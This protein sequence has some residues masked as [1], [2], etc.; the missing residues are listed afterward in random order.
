MTAIDT[1]RYR[2]FL[3]YSHRDAAWGRWFHRALES[4]RIDKGLVGRQTAVGPVPKTLRPIFRDRED[5]SA[6]PSLTN[7]TTAALTASQFLIVLCSPNAA[8]SKYVNEEIRHFKRMGRTDRVIPV[9]VA[10]EPGDPS[11]ECFPPFLRSKIDTVG[12]LIGKEAED[13]IAADARRH[14]DGKERAK[15]K[16]VAAL[17]GVELDEIVRRADRARRSRLRYG[18]GTLAG[19]ALIFAGLA[20]WAEVNRREAVEQRIQAERNF[21]LAKEAADS[22]VHN[23]AMGLNGVEGIRIETVRKILGSAE[24]VINDLARRT[25]DRTD[26]LQSQAGMFGAFADTYATRGDTE[27]QFG[28]AKAALDISERLVRIDPTNSIWQHDLSIAHSKLATAMVAQGNL[29]QAHATYHDALIIM[30]RLARGEPDNPRWQYDLYV[31]H[32]QIG[33]TLVKQGNLDDALKSYFNG[34]AVMQVQARAFPNDRWRQRDLASSANRI[35]TVFKLKGKLPEALRYYR[36]SLAISENLLDAEPDNRIWQHDLS[37]DLDGIG[38]ILVAQGNLSE[39]LTTYRRGA[40]MGKRLSKGDP[41]NAESQRSLAI[42]Y[43]RIGDVLLEQHN[44]I[45]AR[46][47]HQDSLTIRQSLAAA[48]PTNA[49]LQPALAWSYIKLGDV[50]AAQNNLPEA[51]KYFRE[52]IAAAEPVLKV[53]PSNATWQHDLSLAYSRVAKALMQQGNSSESLLFFRRSALI[54]EQLTKTYTSNRQFQHDLSVSSWMIGKI[55]LEQRDFTAAVRAFHDGLVIDQ[56]LVASDPNNLGWQRDLAIS[57]ESLGEALYEHG[58]NAEALQ[59]FH[60]SLA[61]RQALVRSD[62]ANIEWQ[63]EE[64]KP[65][66]GVAMLG[67]IQIEQL[68]LL[69]E[70]LAKAQKDGK[71]PA[72]SEDSISNAELVLALGLNQRCWKRAITG[73][74]EE[75]LADCERSLLLRPQE[76]GTLDSRGFVYLKLG[77]FRE[78]ITDYDAALSLDPANASALYGRGIAKLKK[79]NAAAGRRD[80]AKAKAIKSDIDEEFVRHGVIH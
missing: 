64:L 44:F 22:L 2:A 11:H 69:L 21:T 14:R 68:S 74:L 25:Q 19:V 60:E 71:I 50:F 1:T 23:I 32:N 72:E 35:G 54:D 79:G 41:D 16:V 56:S 27:K 39:A 75:A 58:D 73:K 4:Y 78:S 31:C 63:I 76:A 67:D 10:G 3:S 29:A 42:Y 5:F 7:Q 26:L 38:G 80:I 70:S 30:E 48:D 37:T 8:Q 45:E 34:L 12:E 53:D 20:G 62:P 15:Q 13:P 33:D 9:I 51:L 43:E 77:R 36:E 46:Q 40:A 52:G 17:L 49:G 18:I 59:S 66:L 57:H 65:Q 55:L 28:S 6:G 61:I 47:S 24:Y